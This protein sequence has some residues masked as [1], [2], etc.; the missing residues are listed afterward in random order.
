MRRA[1]SAKSNTLEKK[2][3]IWTFNILKWY[4]S[5]SI[6]SW[7]PYEWG[8]QPSQ[9]ISLILALYIINSCQINSGIT[10]WVFITSSKP[11]DSPQRA[12]AVAIPPAFA[13]PAYFFFV[14]QFNF[15]LDTH[16]QK[17][18]GRFIFKTT[19]EAVSFSYLWRY[20]DFRIETVHFGECSWSELRSRMT[21]IMVHQRDRF[22]PSEQVFTG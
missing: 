10:I 21:L 15:V 3:I 14:F 8:T 19:W 4:T 22:I 1:Y 6:S 5:L 7:S 12:D 2:C 13:S 18:Y 9:L 16:T 11:S 20:A 17:N